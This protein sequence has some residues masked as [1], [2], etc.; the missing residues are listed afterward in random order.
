MS[1]ILL[2]FFLCSHFLHYCTFSIFFQ[3]MTFLPSHFMPFPNFFLFPVFPLFSLFLV[4]L[5][6]T[7]CVFIIFNFVSSIHNL[8][9]HL[10][11]SSVT[12][13]QTSSFTFLLTAFSS[14][15]SLS[16]FDT[17][18][19]LHLTPHSLQSTRARSVRRSL[20]GPLSRME[21]RMSHANTAGTCRATVKTIPPA[22]HR[23]HQ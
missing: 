22:S 6:I 8:F 1:L 12:I 17:Y 7:N 19:S 10:K 2:F 11:I 21:S 14:S 9:F 13:F 5:I 23:P 18:P 20:S 16:L 3:F 15:L 4:A